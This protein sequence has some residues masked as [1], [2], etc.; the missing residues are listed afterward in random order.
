MQK[1]RETIIHILNVLHLTI[2]LLLI[3]DLLE[4]LS[5]LDLLPEWYI[6][7]T[8]LTNFVFK[9]IRSGGW[10][11]WE[12]YI[13]FRKIFF[14]GDSFELMLYFYHNRKPSFI[15]LFLIIRLSYVVLSHLE[16]VLEIYGKAYRIDPTKI[17]KKIKQST[18]FESIIEKITIVV[19]ITVFF[20]V[21]D[22]VDLYEESLYKTMCF[23]KN[24]VMYIFRSM[25]YVATLHYIFLVHIAKILGFVSL[26][27]FKDF[28]FCSIKN[29]LISVF[30]IVHFLLWTVNAVYN[31]DVYADSRGV[32]FLRTKESLLRLFEDK[33]AINRVLFFVY[34][35]IYIFFCYALHN[36]IVHFM[37]KLP[38]KH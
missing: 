18:W 25:Y 33:D 32:V 23:L 15:T 21:S 11:Y 7:I 27:S 10:G 12:F 28:A 4:I 14:F 30:L 29:T 5:N 20:K 31:L 6:N 8:T 36:F 35:A 34:I 17:R 24:T 9:L 22:M 1:M 37:G 3:S 13:G 26:S 38:A 16:D 19:I 2:I